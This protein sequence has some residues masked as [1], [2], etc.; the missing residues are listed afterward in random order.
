MYSSFRQSLQN[1]G[2]SWKLMGNAHAG[3]PNNG[4]SDYAFREAPVI[5]GVAGPPCGGNCSF[6]GFGQESLSEYD[7]HYN[8]S[9]PQ[10]FP[11]NDLWCYLFGL[12][13][14]G[15]APNLYL[16]TT[17]P[18][19]AV[20]YQISSITDNGTF[21]TV[22]CSTPCTNPS[23]IPTDPGQP[24]LGLYAQEG[25]ALTRGPS[26][27]TY[28][29]AQQQYN[30]QGVATRGILNLTQFTCDT[31]WPCTP[32]NQTQTLYVGD[33]LPD[34]IPF[35]SDNYAQTLEIYFCDWEFAFNNANS[36]SVGC[37]GTDATNSQLYR[38]VLNNP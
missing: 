4:D 19:T 11:C 8:P 20:T 35:A 16:Q 28:K 14:T 33:F 10:Q 38:N 25:F 2:A 30:A 9:N 15:G 37:Q 22:T 12:Y 26:K 3:P 5:L 24:I 29:I 6:T 7:L 17:I 27:K 1:S 21:Q 23:T 34:T 31:N 18:N 32:S 13:Q 36:A